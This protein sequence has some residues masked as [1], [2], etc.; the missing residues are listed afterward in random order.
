[1]RDAIFYVGVGALFTH[2]IDAI[3][4]HEWRGLPVLGGL[5]DDVAM[6]IFIALHV[7][8]FALM[9][10]FVASTEPRTR[11]RAKLVVAALLILHG[12]AHFILGMLRPE[13]EFGSLL[14]H[15]LIFGGAACG[16][17]TL[18]LDRFRRAAT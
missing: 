2:E 10:G 17:A 14:S 9:V 7:P 4:N 12:V 5:P 13:Y 11:T 15:V 3:P 1:M 16:A 6:P 8:L 18:L